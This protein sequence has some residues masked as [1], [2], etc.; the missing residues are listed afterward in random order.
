MG[1][2][3]SRTAPTDSVVEATVCAFLCAFLEREPQDAFLQ[4]K[5]SRGY[6]E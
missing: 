4:F 5:I 2:G 3:G 6:N 1:R